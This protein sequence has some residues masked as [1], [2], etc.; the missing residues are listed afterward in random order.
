MKLSITPLT[1]KTIIIL[2]LILEKF[3]EN[4]KLWNVLYEYC[5]SDLLYVCLKDVKINCCK[6][7][8]KFCNKN[9]P[10]FAK[11]NIEFR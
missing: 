1:L 3:A 10:H 9:C 4:M 11:K 8:Y 5:D 7:D 2:G 6:K